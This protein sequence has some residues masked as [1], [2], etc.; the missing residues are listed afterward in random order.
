[1]KSIR[2]RPTATSDPLQSLHLGLYQKEIKFTDGGALTFRVDHQ[3][4]KVRLSD[5]DT[6]EREQPSGT[7]AKQAVLSS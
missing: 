6:S 2:G 1:M 4:L 3:Q 5:L 7:K